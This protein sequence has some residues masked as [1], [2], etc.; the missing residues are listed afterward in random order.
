MPKTNAELAAILQEMADLNEILGANRFKVIA[1]QKAARVVGDHAVALA[2]LGADELKGLDGIGKGV[3]GRIAEWA[4]TG[5]VGE[6]DE[7]RERVPEGLPGLL[8]VPGLG[9]KTVQLLWKEAGVAS[10]EDLKSA[11]EDE[12]RVAAVASIKG[13][14]KKKLEGLRKSLAFLERSAGRVRIGTAMNLAELL[15][16][17]VR[18]FEGVAEATHAGSLRRGRETIGDIDI[19][20]RTDGDEGVRAGIAKAF[21]GMDLVRDVLAEGVTKASVRVAAGDGPEVQVDLRMVPSSSFGA[22]L[23]YFTGSKEHNVAMRERAQVRGMSL[24]EYGLWKGKAPRQGV[25]EADQLVA[26]ASEAEV[27]EALGLAWVP[28]EL[29]EDRGELGKAEADDLP[30]LIEVGD[31]VADLHTHTTASDGALSIEAMAE[32]AMARG[33]KVLAITDHSKSQVQANGL[34][35]ERLLEHAAEVREVARRLKGKITLLA[36][37][38]VDILA[39]G[40]LDYPD[41]VLEQLDVVVASPHAALSQ[42]SEVCTKRLVL[43]IEHPCV[44]IIG[45]PTGRLI[46]RREGLSPDIPR[47]I[48]A[49]RE[50]GV[51]LEINANHYRLDLR[52]AHAAL[53]VKAGVPLSINTDA[54]GEADFGQLRFGVLTA[55]RAGATK[56]DVVNCWGVKKLM[57]WLGA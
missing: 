29:R 24:N 12:E 39:D 20:V 5:R 45:H 40:S 10:V 7:L 32:A 26:G 21:T 36:G 11:L 49:A 52:D 13:M 23:M 56:A 51:A 19:L 9:P 1:L 43:A 28:P 48:E 16:E 14:G 46:N 8:N 57:G 55:R 35:A 25:G 22:A 27:F 54:H 15:L 47:L 34:S 41:E 53:A 17:R 4:Q 37:S 50:H 42:S 6:L 30:R 3:A 2:A 31:V 44:R 18:G 33:L 38:E